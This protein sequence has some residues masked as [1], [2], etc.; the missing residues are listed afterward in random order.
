VRGRHDRRHGRP[1]PSS[2]RACRRIALGAGGPRPTAWHPSISGRE[3]GREEARADAPGERA[4]EG[5]EPGLHERPA[6]GG[7][8]GRQSGR[9]RQVHAV[10]G[11]RHPATPA[12][13]RHAGH[14]RAGA[15]EDAGELHRGV[16]EGVGGRGRAA[17]GGQR[18]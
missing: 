14:L 18:A 17:P 4:R 5:T 16:R 3:Q 13:A 15:V 11:L 8:D 10:V 6:A 7:V 9:A 2:R 1:L 12:G